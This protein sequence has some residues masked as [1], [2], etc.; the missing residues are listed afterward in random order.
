MNEVYNV[1]VAPEQVVVALLQQPAAHFKGGRLSS[2]KWGDFEYFR[3][4]A[5]EA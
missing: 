2:Q 4:V 1:G 3:L 5:L